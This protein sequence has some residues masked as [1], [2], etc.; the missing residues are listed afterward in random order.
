[1]RQ[2]VHELRSPLN[3]INGFAQLIDGQYFGPVAARYRQLAQS[4]MADACML[5][6]AFDDLDVAARLD[7]GSITPREGQ[8]DLS[9]TVRMAIGTVIVPAGQRA[10]AID[11]SGLGA[12]IITPIVQAD[13]KRIITRLLN[14]LAQIAGADE[15]LTGTLEMDSRDDFVGLHLAR[16]AQLMGVDVQPAFGEAH[17]TTVN[18]DASII[19][20]APTLHLV[21]QLAA[22]HGGALII[23]DDQFIL[24]LPSLSNDSDRV[25]SSG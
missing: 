16:P 18:G 22:L 8:C 24:N 17:Q 13:V 1:M 5:G 14:A 10:V 23:T 2:M 21:N 9:E 11:I 20:F 12:P 15:K 3:A 4:I 6:L 25:G 19:G 7:M